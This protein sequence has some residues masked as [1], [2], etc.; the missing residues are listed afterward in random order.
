M[1]TWKEFP[2]WRV[3]SGLRHYDIISTR[4]VSFQPCDDSILF[5]LSP[6]GTL[7]LFARDPEEWSDPGG[8]GTTHVIVECDSDGQHAY[9]CVSRRYAD[10]DG[11]G[12][13]DTEWWWDGLDWSKERVE[14]RDE[15][16]ESMGY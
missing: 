11:A 7:E 2:T 10:C 4:G 9:A 8:W 3:H 15:R 13:H 5:R 16:A 6:G 12:G 14:C 1:N